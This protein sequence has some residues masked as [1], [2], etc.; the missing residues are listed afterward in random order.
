MLASNCLFAF[1]LLFSHLSV[2][3]LFSSLAVV[4][5]LFAICCSLLFMRIRNPNVIVLISVSA[6]YLTYEVSLF[7]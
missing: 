5:L 1:V 6:G 2:I 7:L 4:L 3:V